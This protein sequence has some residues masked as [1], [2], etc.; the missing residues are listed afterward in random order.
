MNPEGYRLLTIEK[1][2]AKILAKKPEQCASPQG[3]A[4]FAFERKDPPLSFEES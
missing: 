1:T 4:R 2:R 3:R